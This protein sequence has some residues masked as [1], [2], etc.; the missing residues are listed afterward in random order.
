MIPATFLIV[1]CFSAVHLFAARLR[2]L[3]IVPR[4]RWLSAAGGISVAYVF[5][6][7]L[8]ELAAGRQHLEEAPGAELTVYILALAGL[9]TFYGLERLVK[10][11]AASGAGSAGVFWLHMGSF[12]LY[13]LLIGYLTLHRE[14]SGPL[15]LL[16]YAVAFG[17][18]FL[19]NDFGLREDHEEAYDRRGRWL[20]A[21]AVL[22]GWA[23]GIWVDISEAHVAALL[24]FLSG[25]VILNVMKEELPR[26]RESRFSAFL[27]G[28][29]LY[30]A[31]LLLA[32]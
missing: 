16:F 27:A 7:I 21:G 14:A 4:S 6:H 23:L 25:G 10:R 1:L 28:A 18:H 17:L 12:T 13:N 2:F 11:P 8:P 20:L 30:S 31:L 19:T 3:R 32:G 26:E 29:L 24:A 15:A 22:I 9:T 5:L